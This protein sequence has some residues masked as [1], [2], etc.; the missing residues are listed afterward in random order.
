MVLIYFTNLCSV[1]F[2]DNDLLSL[3]RRFSIHCDLTSSN[4]KQRKHEYY[5]DYIYTTLH[6]R[7]QER[8]E[9][10]RERVERA[11]SSNDLPVIKGYEYVSSNPVFRYNTKHL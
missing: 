6:K 5:N 11:I 8:E 9:A 2:R 1:P 10:E 4:D 3:L 7:Y